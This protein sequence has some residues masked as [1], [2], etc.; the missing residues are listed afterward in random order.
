[1]AHTGQDVGGVALD[2]HAPAASVALLAAPEFAVEQCLIHL[3]TGR[4]AGNKGDQSLAVGFSCGEVAQHKLLIVPDAD[5]M[6]LALLHSPSSFFQRPLGNE[7][8]TITE[9]S[10]SSAY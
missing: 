8:F 7:E 6:N 5:N 10:S 3:Q 4:N 2:L 1:M 9:T